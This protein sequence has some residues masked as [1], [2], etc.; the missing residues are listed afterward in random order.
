MR[1]QVFACI[2]ITGW[3][4]VAATEG[5]PTVVTGIQAAGS[6]G[7]AA[8]GSGAGTL[9]PKGRFKQEGDNC[10]WDAKDE[11][12]NQCTPRVPGRFKQEKNGCVWDAKDNGPDQCTP[13]KGRWKVDGE[14]CYWDAKDEGPHQC[15][16]RQRRKSGQ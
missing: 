12:P 1:P 9:Q 5:A 16:P 14:R 11:G 8:S 4:L 7:L 6:Y 10:V 15:N 13:P 3:T 2:A